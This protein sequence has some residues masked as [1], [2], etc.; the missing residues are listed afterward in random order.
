MAFDF[1]NANVE[2]RE[3]ITTCDGPLLIIAGPGTGKTYTLVKRIVYLITEK[4]AAPESILVATFTEKAAK[5]LI[6]RI[7]NELLALNISVNLND[8]YV[9]TFHSICLRILGEHLEKSSMKKNYRQI[10]GFEQQYLVYRKMNRFLT[11]PDFETLL[12]PNKGRWRNAKEIVSYVNLLSEELVDINEMKQDTDPKIVLIANM[13]EQYRAIVEEENLIDFSRMQTETYELLNTYPEILE[14]LQEKI[15]YIMVDEYQDTNFIQEQIIFMI[16]GL[17]QNICV[18][19]DDDQGLYRFRG[20]TIRNILEFPEKFMEGYCKQVKLVT[21]YR[22]EKDIIDFY[23]RWMSQT[24]G[25]NFAFDW[26]K[27]RFPKEIKAGKISKNRGTSVFKCSSLEYVEEWYW[28]VYSF[29]TSLKQNQVVSDYNQIAFL[30]RSVKNKNVTGLIHFLEKN[31]VPVYS[32]RSEMFFKRVEVRQAIGC[33]MLCFPQYM[34]KYNKREFQYVSR[35]LYDYLDGCCGAVQNIYFTYQDSLGRW[36]DQ[37][38]VEH[39]K[40]TEHGVGYAFS[41]LLY[42]LFSCEPFRTYLSAPIK[43]SVLDARAAR[44]LSKLIEFCDKFEFINRLNQF[45]KDNVEPAVER[46]MNSYLRLLYEEGIAEF[47][48]DSE[49]APRGCV[50]FMTIHQAKGMEFP[51]VMVDSLDSSPSYYSDPVL[52]K[53]EDKYF[54]R[55]AFEHRDDVRYFDFWRLY[56]TAFSRAQNLLVLTCNERRWSR[57]SPSVFFEDAYERLTNYNEINW[58]QWNLEQIKPVNVK[59]TYSFTSH[60]ALYEKCPLQY[61]FFKELGF[62]RQRIEATLFGTLVHETIEDIHRAVIRG[63]ELEF[64]VET[65]KEW[66]DK[67]YETLSKGEHF[68]LGQEQKKA[69]FK[70]VLHYVNRRKEEFKS[71][72][73]AEMEVSMIKSDFI[74]MGKIDLVCES[75]EYIELFDFKSGKRPGEG[76]EDFLLQS[77][78]KQL[79]VY[80]YL[81]EQKTG[82]KVNKMHL[83]YTGEEQK[84]PMISFDYSKESI[85]HTITD[86]EEAVQNI[87]QKKFD[88]MCRDRKICMGCEMKYY[89][90]GSNGL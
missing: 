84:N 4:K 24:M 66:F 30:C 61:K 83:Y 71:I 39:Q 79:E 51:V 20:A 87:E 76:G 28:N 14:K 29:I 35:E 73:A 21:N 54:K 77:Y 10:D 65:V 50:S 44:N 45:N 72:R 63:E 26:G 52:E 80:A 15:H 12:P 2:Q 32:P 48:D 68:Y 17:R 19:G 8:M 60:I 23:N 78:R 57:P 43:G 86:F 38:R 69:A 62:T 70:Q 37:K 22:S 59:E 88:G 16:G 58:K 41:G 3:A 53:I 40:M 18:V 6:T 42:Q 34:Q 82:K 85:E 89:C 27:F 67:N 13:V 49:Y 7:T 9:G 11:L 31:G 5:E 55:A 74:L 25:T 46:F 33:I 36:M 90:Y 64:D 1:G 75:G 47:E 81:V 56:Y